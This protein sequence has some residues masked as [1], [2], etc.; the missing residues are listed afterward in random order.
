M[1]FILQRTYK[2]VHIHCDIRN[3]CKSIVQF[4]LL[5]VAL[6]AVR[7]V[8]YKKSLNKLNKLYATLKNVTD[9]FLYSCFCDNTLLLSVLEHMY[10]VISHPET[11]DY[12]GLNRISTSISC[13][14]TRNRTEMKK[15][16]WYF[17]TIM[18]KLLY[19]YVSN[20]NIIFL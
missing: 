5:K 1:H 2:Y 7:L 16:K 12:L 14:S 17:I 6:I 13:T 20:I 8:W 9:S 15:I 11:K 4:S 3:I 19:Y 10:Q 18:E